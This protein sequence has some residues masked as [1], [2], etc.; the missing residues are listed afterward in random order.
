MSYFFLCGVYND[1]IFSVCIQINGMARFYS[2]KKH[3]K[4][5]PVTKKHVIRTSNATGSGPIRDRLRR[6]LGYSCGMLKVF[7]LRAV[8]RVCVH[9]VCHYV[10]TDRELQ[11]TVLTALTV[12]IDN[13]SL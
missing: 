1:L 11:A 9:E 7:A 12:V 5:P 8:L 6:F 3:K 2:K 4:I 13:M 10:I